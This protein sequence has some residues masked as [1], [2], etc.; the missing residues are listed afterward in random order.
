MVNTGQMVFSSQDQKWDHLPE[1]CFPPVLCL[2]D[3]HNGQTISVY[4]CSVRLDSKWLA[5]II[6]HKRNKKA[7]IPPRAKIP[8]DRWVHWPDKLVNLSWPTERKK[9]LCIHDDKTRFGTLPADFLLVKQTI[10]K[11]SIKSCNIFICGSTLLLN[12]NCRTWQQ[13]ADF[14][15]FIAE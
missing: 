9:I 14:L 12:H 6:T 7:Q 13:M 2:N 15:I 4:Y 3:W 10:L 5:G 11:C 8:L 1:R